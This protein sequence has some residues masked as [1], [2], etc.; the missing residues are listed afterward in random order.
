MHSLPVLEARGIGGGIA[1]EEPIASSVGATILAKEGNAVDAAVAVSLSL[2]VVIPHLGGIGGDFFAFIHTPNGNVDFVNGSGPAPGRLSRDLFT[3][4]GLRNIPGRGPLSITVPG[5]FAGLYEVW[6]RYGQMEWRELVEPAAK[7]ARDGFPVPQSLARAV[8]ALKDEL[9]SD[10]GWRRTYSNIEEP[11]TIAR[12]PGLARLLEGVS[13]DPSFFYMGEPSKAIEEYVS[14]R[15]GVLTARDLASFKPLTGEPVSSGYGDWTLYE[16]PPNTQGLTT[17]HIMKILEQ[18]NL[19]KQAERR[20][21][22]I[23]AASWPAYEARDRELG[24]PRYMSMSVK[25]LLSDDY[26]GMLRAVA[27]KGPRSCLEVNYR[28]LRGKDTTFFAVADKEGIMVAGIQSLFYPFGSGLVEPRFQIPLNGRAAG[29]TLQSGRPNILEPGKLPLHTLSAVIGVSEG[30]VLALG[31]S[32]GH[33]RPQQHALMLTSIIDNGYSPG[34]AISA[35]RL[36]WAPWTCKVVADTISETAVVSSGYEV[37]TGRTGVANAIMKYGRTL[38]VATD[39]RGD[40]YPYL[41]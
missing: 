7:L 11:G 1:S 35:P 8:K 29:F 14:E 5:Y 31:A 30:K 19:P 39:P 6:R 26:I 34:E 9:S 22:Y 24:D 41:I 3:A 10:P 33:F 36:L 40:G 38:T 18:W 17:L 27:R 15:G 13:E 25:E 37:I 16:M 21:Y 23:L 28:E 12:F 20:F 32:G 2:A 4:K